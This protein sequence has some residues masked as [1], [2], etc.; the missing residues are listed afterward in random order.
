MALYVGDNGVL[1]LDLNWKVMLVFSIEL[2]VSVILGIV[3]N[4]KKNAQKGRL[5]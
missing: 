5:Y 2:I 1:Q 3:Y 4:R